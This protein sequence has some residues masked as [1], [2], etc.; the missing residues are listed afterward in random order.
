MRLG[1]VIVL[2]LLIGA[3]Y[4]ARG[5]WLPWLPQGW[6]EDVR[7]ATIGEA[8]SAPESARIYVWQNAAGEWQYTDQPPADRSFEVR[9]Y[10]EDVNVVPSTGGSRE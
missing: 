1:S 2:L 6:V 4:L 10:R 3:L 5:W 8:G 9:Q 7:E